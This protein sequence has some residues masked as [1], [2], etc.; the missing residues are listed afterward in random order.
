MLRRALVAASLTFAT[1]AS[2]NG[3]API[4]NGVTL[5]P[6]DPSMVLVRTTF[7]LL[8]SRDAGCSFRWVC[9]QDIG[10]GGT[11]DP[12]YA[13]AADG[14]IFATT[15]S[16]LRV[17]HDGGCSF[18]TATS[19]LPAGSPGRIADIWVDALA[20]APTGDVWVATAESGQSNDVYRST[21]NGVTF[22]AM[23]QASATIFWK[24]IAVA[25]S[26]P[27]RVY[28]AGYELTPAPAG[29]LFSTTNGGA[30]W[31]PAPLTGVMVAAA[32]QL[33]IAA[34]DPTDAQK[35]FLVSGAS[36]GDTGDRL[37][38][39]VDGGATFTEVLTTTEPI[40][41]VVIKDA[42][43]VLVANG[44]GG[45]FRSTDA[46]ASFAAV[47]G[48]PELGCIGKRAD[49]SLIGCATNWDPDFM[50]VAASTD[51]TQW[52]KVFRF[53][54]IGGPLACPAGTAGHDVCDVQMWPSLRDQFGAT[55][56]TCPTATDFPAMGADIT[57]PGSSSGC[58]DAGDG[59]PVGAT[60]L[61][62]GTCVLALRR[63]QRA[64]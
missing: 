23:N 1:F 31:T 51:A 59:S 39:S 6:N 21:D 8:I 27:Q 52:Q 55:G 45:T 34:V 64:A 47:A 24:S 16:G 12:T 38:R 56:P 44:K 49:G 18:T 28:V 48:A 25:P 61:A 36:N 29:H 37:Y 5:A 20:I 63:K 40:A 60:L 33:T 43:T 35:L 22:T 7:G 42:T 30:T 53:I 3:R 50:A 19:Q 2:A 9:E 58:C 54:E 4:T 13:I 14:T 17:S 46:G 11:F 10:Y 15:F 26:D 32:P 41:G 62:I 57:D